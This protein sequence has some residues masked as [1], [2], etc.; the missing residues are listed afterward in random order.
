MTDYTL[1]D[2]DAHI[3]ETPD[4]W[5]A[6]TPAKYRDRV[7]Q[8]PRVD[9]QDVWFIVHEEDRMAPRRTRVERDGVLRTA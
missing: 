6:R 7:P 3:T 4:T 9:G 5:V 2:V 1:I 8:V